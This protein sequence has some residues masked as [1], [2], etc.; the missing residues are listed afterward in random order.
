[1]RTNMR[2]WGWL[3]VGLALLLSASCGGNTGTSLAEGGISGT[4]ITTVGTISG[5]GSMI[6][7]GVRYELS[8]ASFERDGVSVSGQQDYRVGELV[9]IQ[10]TLLQDRLQGQASSVSYQTQLSD[11]V[12]QASLDGVTLEVL[13]QTVRVTSLSVLHGFSQ[14]QQLQP[15]DWVQVSG[16]RDAQGHW[17]ASSLLLKTQGF[18]EGVDQQRVR[19]EV[20]SVDDQN[21]RLMMGRLVI[22]FS[23]LPES[24]TESLESGVLIEVM[25]SRALTDSDV[26]I[27]TGLSLLESKSYSLG[28]ELEI[29]GVIDQVIG[30]GHLRMDGLDVKYDVST[31][32]EYGVSTDL[33]PNAWIEVEGRVD[34]EGSLVAQKI[35]IKRQSD[36]ADEQELEGII[37]SVDVLTGQLTVSGIVVQ[38]DARTVLI[39]EDSDQASSLRLEQLNSGDTVEV[40][41]RTLSDGVRLAVKIELE[42]DD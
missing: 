38:T 3:K 34:A 11:V 29:E 24:A 20:L 25:S 35:E 41:Y 18:E 36:G 8:G 40:D 30:D 19:G 5:F 28:A 9:T 33:V 39:R 17:V 4:G 10:G 6:V 7:N 26:L 12:T 14:L 31:E 23:G 32:F 1:M 16:L 37:T 13:G 27:A 2:V 15:G 22:D 42:T 21:Q